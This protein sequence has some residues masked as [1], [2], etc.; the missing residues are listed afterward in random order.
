MDNRNASIFGG[1][2]GFSNAGL[3]E[4]TN[5]NTFKT[6]ATYTYSVDGVFY[7][8]AATDNL[9]FSAGHT[10]LGNSEVCLFGVWVDAAGAIT[11]SQ[12]KIVSAT[13]L[14]NGTVAL[15]MPDPVADKALVGLIRVETGA[16]A[17]FTPGSTDLGAAGITDTYYNTTV[18]PA[19]ALF[20]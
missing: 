14:S 20:A 10:A 7:S 4:G 1:N 3:A 9:P 12:G 15:E 16:S 18:R 19:K 11:T 5:A 17:T 8:K 6:A 2:V 13:A